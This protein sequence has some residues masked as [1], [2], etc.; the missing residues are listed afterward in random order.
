MT[1]FVQAEPVELIQR[2]LREFQRRFTR[3]MLK[4]QQEEEVQYHS[5][6]VTWRVPTHGVNIHRRKHKIRPHAHNSSSS[7]TRCALCRCVWSL[8]SL[9]ESV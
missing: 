1:S 8:G 2:R 5:L 3:I 4:K 9:L 6:N 7:Q